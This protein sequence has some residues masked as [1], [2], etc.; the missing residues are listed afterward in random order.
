MITTEEGASDYRGTQP[1][2][3]PQ[4]TTPPQQTA[5]P[6]QTTSYSL[7]VSSQQLLTFPS[8]QQAIIFNSLN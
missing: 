8:K 1:K 6:Q 3:T 4:Q 5:P 7:A 2:K